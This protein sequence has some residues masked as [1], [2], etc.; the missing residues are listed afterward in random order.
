[1]AR[2]GKDFDP[3]QRSSST[4]RMTP[5]IDRTYAL[6]LTAHLAR[7]SRVDRKREVVPANVDARDASLPTE[8]KG[9]TP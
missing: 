4:P 1:M 5:V 6:F 9:K 7:Q 8:S 2:V 3:S